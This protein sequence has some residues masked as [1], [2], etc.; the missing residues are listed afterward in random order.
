[1]RPRRETLRVFFL[2]SFYYFACEVVIIEA[3]VVGGLDWD[4]PPVSSA[5]ELIAS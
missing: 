3:Q 5:R 4:P 1:M 2:T